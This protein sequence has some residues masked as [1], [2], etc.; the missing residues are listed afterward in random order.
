MDN[1]K[2]KIIVDTE[3]EGR[4]ELEKNIKEWELYRS[5]LDMSQ[6]SVRN[7]AKEMDNNL[8]TAVDTVNNKLSK[9]ET[10]GFKD[11]QEQIKKT[12]AEL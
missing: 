11:L 6:K 8:I 2:F 5:T 1:D 10:Q 7:L 3:F 12:E 4:E 9:V